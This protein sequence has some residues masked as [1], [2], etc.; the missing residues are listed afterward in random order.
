MSEQAYQEF[1]ALPVG[2]L[3]TST[4]VW[5][6]QDAFIKVEHDRYRRTYDYIS[7]DADGGGMATP[8]CNAGGIGGIRRSETDDTSGRGWPG[9][10]TMVEVPKWISSKPPLTEAE[11]RERERADYKRLD[12]YVKKTGELPEMGFW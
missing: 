11:C 1:L 9:I 12:D 6:E 5:G 2:A 7:W 8:G 10:R 4:A 3:F